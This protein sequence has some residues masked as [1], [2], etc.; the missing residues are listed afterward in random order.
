MA[1]ILLSDEEYNFFVNQE[2]DLLERAK[3]ASPRASTHLRAVAKMHSDFLAREEGKR[4]AKTTKAAA[5]QE[6]EALKIQRQQ[7]RLAAL[8]Q[9]VQQSKAQPQAAGGQN[10]TGQRRD[11]GTS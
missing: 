4:A 5:Q 10:P 3:T 8:Q 11:R 1:A 6:R 9:R 7:E 2:K